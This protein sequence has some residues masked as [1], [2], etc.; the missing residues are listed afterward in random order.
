MSKQNPLDTQ[1]QSYVPKNYLHSTSKGFSFMYTTV[2][3]VQFYGRCTA[4]KSLNSVNKEVVNYL[5]QHPY[6]LRKKIC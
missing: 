6:D 4:L 3:S 1:T 2:K 5:R